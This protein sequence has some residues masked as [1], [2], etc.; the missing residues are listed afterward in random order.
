MIS[1]QTK[2]GLFV[3]VG[4]LTLAVS[5]FLI[6]DNKQTWAPKVPYVARFKDVAG[7][8][9]GA[10]V[11]LGGVDIGLVT[12]VGYGTSESDALIYVKVS[13]KRSEAVR[14]RVGTKASV[15][16]MGMLGDKML[17]LKVTDPHATELEPGGALEADE[18]DDIVAKLQGAVGKISDRLDEIG[19]FTKPLSDPKFVSSVTNIVS[20][21]NEITTSIAHEDSAAHRLLMDPR[22]GERIDVALAN[23]D[24]ATLRL[25]AILGSMQDVAD[26]VRGGPGIAHAIIYDGEM[27]KNTAGTLDEIHKDLEAIRKGNGLAHAVVYGDDATQHV[28]GNL[29]ATSDDLRAIVSDV[30]AGKGTLGGLLVDPTIYEDLKTAVGNVERNQ[31]LRALVRYAIKEDEAQP[32]G[33]RGGKAGGP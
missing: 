9:A 15:A 11:K 2:V 27:S 20:T 12:H 14:I 31:V 16:M 7:L 6:G 8:K 13:V 18:G 28:L 21:V 30:R 4:I 5:V 25:A 1:K 17:V 24:T 26:H 23:L 22:E 19:A 32:R 29:N 3:I 10:P 33:G